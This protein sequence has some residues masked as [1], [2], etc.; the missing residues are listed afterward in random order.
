MLAVSTDTLCLFLAP[1]K[2]SQPLTVR[3]SPRRQLDL[4]PVASLTR[5]GLGLHA[6]FAMQ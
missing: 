3:R 4:V 2:Q 5:I 6:R 1:L